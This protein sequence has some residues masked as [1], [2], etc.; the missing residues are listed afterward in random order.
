MR[1]EQVV[2][3]YAHALFGVAVDKNM[4]ETIV[5]EIDRVMEYIADPE[6]EG[7]FQSVNLDGEA[8]KSIFNKAFLHEVS[9]ITRNFFWI[10]FDNSRE[11]LLND[12]RNEFERLADEHSKRMVAKIITAVPISD[13]LKSRVRKQL[14]QATKKEVQVEAV[15]DPSIY[16]GM[17]IYADNQIIDASVKSRLSDLRDRLVQAR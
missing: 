2:R 10:V 4:L 6:F 8:K 15:V 3:E 13:K 12:I 11:N 17:I 7:F 9:V 1:N 16:G 14:E 5:K